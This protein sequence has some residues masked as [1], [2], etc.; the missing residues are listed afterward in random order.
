MEINMEQIASQSV[1]RHSLFG[2][3]AFI[4]GWIPLCISLGYLGYIYAHF[5]NPNS[6]SINVPLAILVVSISGYLLSFIAFIL[7][8]IALFQKDRKKV[9]AIL[10]I[11]VSLF[12][13]GLTALSFFTLFL[14]T[15]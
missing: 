14:F 13:C 10:G 6:I 3:A 9:F 2:I 8:V 11:I 7:G 15:S 5:T 1:R 12:G 4:V